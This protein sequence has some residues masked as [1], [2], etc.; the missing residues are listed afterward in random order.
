VCA[1]VSS[2]DLLVPLYKAIY[3]GT[4]SGNEYHEEIPKF[5]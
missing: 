5:C 1:K 4:E 2:E 3:Y